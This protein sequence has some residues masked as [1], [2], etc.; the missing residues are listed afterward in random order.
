MKN[1]ILLFFLCISSLAYSQKEASNWYFGE[2]AGIH[3]NADGT[4]TP[5]TDG[6]LITL[7]GCATLS[8]SNGNLLF[9]TDGSTVYNKKHQIMLNGTGLKGHFS[10]SQSATIVPK[11][12]S[13]NLFYVFTVDEAAKING[14]Q[15]SEIDLT[16]DGGLGG[17]TANKNVL[18]YT[19]S[20]EKISVIKQS[21]NTDL[22]IVT[23]GWNSN[24][25]YAHLLTA[26]GLSATPISSSVGGFIGGTSGGP[27]QNNVLGYMKISPDGTKLAAGHCFNFL[28][29]FDFDVATGKVSNPI[30]LKSNS[31]YQFYGVE[32]SPNSKVLYVAV[33]NIQQIY[34]Y[35]LTASNIAAS[36]RLIATA[37]NGLGALQL[38]PNNKIYIANYDVT[39][40]GVINNPD[41]IGL[42]CNLQTNAVALGGKKSQ[43]GLPCFVQSFFNSSFT[44]NNQCLGDLTTY[45]LS[46]NQVIT[47]ATWDFGDGSTSTTVSPTHTYTATGTYTVSVTATGASGTS[48]N[49][50]DIT[51]SALPTATKPQDIFICDSN[52]D[53]FSTFDLTT[54]NTVILNGQDPNLFSIKY[55][56]NAADYSNKTAIVTPNNYVN[57]T[58]YQAQT[59]IAEVSNNANSECKS[60]TSFDIDVFDSPK[61]NTIVQKMSSCDNASVGTDADGRVLFDLTQR[62]T[63]I[64]N[65]Q[66]ASQ[67]VLSYFKDS[68]LTIGIATPNA[69]A[70]TTN[71]D[72]AACF[73]TTSFPIEVLALPVI[74]STVA[75]KQ[76]DDNIDGFSVFN[77]EEAIAKITVNAV[78][79]TIVFY[80][81]STDAQNNTVPI[82]NTTTYT[83]QVVSNDAV[84]AKV[85]NAN[86]C[87][88]ISK[89]NLLVSTTQ[90]PLNYAKSFTQCD[91][92]ILGTS[93]DGIASFDFSSVTAE[94]QNIFPA[95]QLLDI[96][97]FRN[98][99]D[100]LAEKNAIA[101]IS[102]YRNIGYPSTQK[103]YIRVDSQV[104][105]D[106]LGLG[107][108]I[109]LNV[110]RIP[111]VQ[112]LT[113]IHC[114]DDQDGKFD[115]DTNTLETQL[116]NGLNNV[117]VEYFDQNNVQLSTPLPNPFVTSSQKL[118]V[119]VTN[120]T[121][122]ACSYE[123]TIDFLV[124]DLPEAF[125]VA[126]NLTT[127]CDDEADPNL[128][129]GKYTFDTATFQNNILGTQTGMTVKYFD[130][131][132][133]LL[134][135]PLPNPFITK[136]QKVRV[137][138]I[139][140]VNTTCTATITLPF[141]VNPIPKIALTG[142]ELVCSN[143]PTFTKVL[144]AGILDSSPPTDYSYVWSFN[145]NT[146]AGEIYYTLTVNTAGLYTVKVTNNQ[147]C[148]RTRTFTVVAS[149]KANITDVK[150]VDLAESNS[151]TVSVAASLGDYVYALDDENG[152]Y[153]T[154]NVFENV[155]A[156]IHTVFVKDLNRCGIERKE[157]AVLGIPNFFTPN[158]D[159]NN[160]YWN[161]KGANTSFNASTIIYIFDRY[162]KLVKQISPI[163]QGWDGTFNGL[164]MPASDYWYSIQLEDSRVVKGHFSLKR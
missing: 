87:Y 34:Q 21:N 127:I 114:D 49:T 98:L 63:T 3:F 142:D 67:F 47:S 96:R 54:Q 125:P 23:H 77:L 88:R 32:F 97:Y 80:K 82:T 159:G 74:T 92:V 113:L 33:S 108:H 134:A 132:N 18:V 124:D 145:G 38:G 68:A 27:G 153:Q 107:N 117:S 128:Q 78:N 141:I 123:S 86:G 25:F 13:P 75:L 9:Y 154:D 157:V 90:I 58:G 131:N 104:N 62:A 7:E 29:L 139:N 55:F 135:T 44:V 158:N 161:I 45:A 31:F 72:N 115:F 120:T 93:T 91:D 137:E 151:I 110:E 136:T 163:T 70:N 8:D 2:G 102:N 24:T 65:G 130:A 121:T 17:I 69:Y 140:P 71:K 57:T 46:G 147:G 116:L 156:G 41:I 53:G 28:E 164:Q 11:P 152:T 40:L 85:S 122:K 126:T 146:I 22:W 73:A 14:V 10:S 52:N 144:D 155:P 19:P 26:S 105:N 112:T 81:S 109:T 51:I 106:C 43:N 95:G 119:I 103:I 61:P 59:I 150:I 30:R 133:N 111:I 36:E 89:V 1:Q 35:N 160:D 84:Y 138:V 15:Y 148:S 149:D 56:A 60:T 100:A 66:S 50:K 99:A 48:T 6:K 4:V 64:L 20:L 101:D 5:L 76:C 37:P 39:N 162:G 12:G 94:I 143:L 16:L 42:G 83:N 129:N 118:K 79:E